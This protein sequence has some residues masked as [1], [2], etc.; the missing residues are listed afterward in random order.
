MR[1]FAATCSGALLFAASFALLVYANEPT[2]GTAVAGGTGIVLSGALFGLTFLAWRW[3]DA[4]R[5][6]STTIVDDPGFYDELAATFDGT[7]SYDDS[8]PMRAA[9]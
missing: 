5:A 1:I 4:P 2:D 9:N 7:D 8:P 6:Y 3:R